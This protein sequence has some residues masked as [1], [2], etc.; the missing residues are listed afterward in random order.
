MAACNW[1][2]DLAR[3]SMSGRFYGYAEELAVPRR[4]SALGDPIT[5]VAPH[6]TGPCAGN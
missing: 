6:I 3:A 1:Q 5:R 4:S 2:E